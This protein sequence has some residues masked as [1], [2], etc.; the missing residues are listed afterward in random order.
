MRPYFLP[1][2]MLNSHR[3]IRTFISFYLKQ[4]LIREFIGSHTHLIHISYAS[5]THPIRWGYYA[6]RIRHAGDTTR[7]ISD[8]QH[9][10][11]HHTLGTHRPQ[12]TMRLFV[13]C[14]TRLV[15]FCCCWYLALYLYTNRQPRPKK[16]SH[17]VPLC[18][19]GPLG[20]TWLSNLQFQC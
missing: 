8:T 11:A 13:Q 9:S 3:E 16:E 1:Y 17:P 5:H 12:H 2:E 4:H 10:R 14:T 7:S 19:V 18:K 20:R 6:Q 15:C